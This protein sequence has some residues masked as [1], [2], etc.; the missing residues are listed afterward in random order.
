MAFTSAHLYFDDVAL[1][2][3]WTSQGRTI[4]QADI[5]NF[6]GISGDFNPIHIDAEFAKTTLYR[7]PIA[8]GMLVW[9]IGTGLSVYAPM[10]RTL[11]FMSVRE[12][13]FKEPVFIGDTIHVTAKVVA[14]EERSRGRRGVITWHRTILNQNDKIVQEGYTITM[15]EGRAML[16]KKDGAET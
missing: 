5:V 12:W 2:Q 10:M 11:A 1:D 7:Q 4:T 8:H 9:S 6:A 3:E 15:V 14:K 13:S 16:L